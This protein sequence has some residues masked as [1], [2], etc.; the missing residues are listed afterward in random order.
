MAV[1]GSAT[2]YAWVY[3]VSLPQ[4]EV[5]S[6]CLVDMGAFH[7][8]GEGGRFSQALQGSLVCGLQMT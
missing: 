6:Q 5:K 1:V 8:C 7:F 2:I 3:I 4:L